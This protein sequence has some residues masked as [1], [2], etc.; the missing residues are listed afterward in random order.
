[1]AAIDKRSNGRWRVRIRNRRAPTLS[2]TFTR[3]ADAMK[4][5]RDTEILIEKVV[6]INSF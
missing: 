2:K 1:M 3:K 6:L 5:A 4:W